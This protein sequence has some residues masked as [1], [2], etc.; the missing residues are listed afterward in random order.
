MGVLPGHR[1]WRIVSPGVLLV[2]LLAAHQ[3]ALA[4]QPPQNQLKVAYSNERL[5]R[6]PFE[7]DAE[8]RKRLS[9]VYLYYSDGIDWIYAGATAPDKPTFPFRADHDGEYLFAVRTKDRNNRLYPPDNQ[10]VEPRLKV[11]VD[12]E[13]PSVVLRD[14]PRRGGEIPIWWR[15]IDPNLDLSTFVIEYRIQ[16]APANEWR[17]VQVTPQVFGQYRLDVGTGLAV[18]IRISVTDKAGNLGTRSKEIAAVTAIAAPDRSSVTPPDRPLPLEPVRQE[19]P[20]TPGFIE[21][22][23]GPEDDPFEGIFDR[24]SSR[25]TPPST[26]QASTVTPRPSQPA[27]RLDP[28]FPPDPST[29]SEAPDPRSATTTME[30]T[31]PS[32]EAPPGPILVGSRT[33]P[34]QYDVG[35]ISPDLVYTVEMWRSGDQG[36]TWEI[37]GVDPDRRSPI[38][39][40][41]PSD[42]L[43]GLRIVISD[44]NN[45]GDPRPEQGTPPQFEVIVDTTKPRI[46]IDSVRFGTGETSNTLFITYRTEEQHPAEFPVVLEIKPDQPDGL[47]RPIGDRR[48]PDSGTFAWQLPRDVPARF[49]LRAIANDAVG[50]FRIIEWPQPISSNL[51]RPRGRILGLDPSARFGVSRPRR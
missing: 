10:P 43:H 34:L 33:I 1:G 39:V 15:V 8:V 51:A 29:L 46:G 38:Q 40:E 30:A 16:G 42:G 44:R 13:K 3:V 27:S 35:E 21:E 49:R 9:E 12:T 36:R 26:S 19:L 25:T 11:V 20:E 24:A 7:V 31:P 17:R 32:A 4:K 28:N 48:L 2:F 6:I 14:S 41:L 47:W 18:V 37:I 5:F 22:L 23:P 45:L 50:N